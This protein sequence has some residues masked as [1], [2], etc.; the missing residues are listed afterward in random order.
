MDRSTF[1]G[2][3]SCS[4]PSIQCDALDRSGVDASSRS[5]PHHLTTFL[6]PDV[7]V[8]GAAKAERSRRNCVQHWLDVRGGFRDDLQD[9]CR[10]RLLL[11]RFAELGEKA[12]VLDG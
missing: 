12:N 6:Q 3:A 10:R 5:G 2:G 8:V 4:S 7:D 9:F 11:Q 1:K